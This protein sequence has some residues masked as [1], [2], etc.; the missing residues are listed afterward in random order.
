MGS[1]AVSRKKEEISRAESRTIED[2]RDEKVEK[3]KREKL[4]D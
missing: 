3:Q 2:E 4:D 1:N